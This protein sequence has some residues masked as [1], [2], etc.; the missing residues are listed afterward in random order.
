[1]KRELV[2]ACAF[3]ILHLHSPIKAQQPLSGTEKN[4]SAEALFSY[5]S[6]VLK[7]AGRFVRHCVVKNEHPTRPL[8][9]KWEAADLFRDDL[10]P[11]SSAETR[12]SPSSARPSERP[13]RINY[14]AVLSYSNHAEIYINPEE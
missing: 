12:S 10:K 14:G 7:E 6:E 13:S 5:R 2:A 11:G 4:D 1:M 3:V 9:F 8:T